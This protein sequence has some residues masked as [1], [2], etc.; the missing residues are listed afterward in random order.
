MTERRKFPSSPFFHGVFPLLKTLR[1]FSTGGMR[2]SNICGR[3]ISIFSASVVAS[4]TTFSVGFRQVPCVQHQLNFVGC[5]VL[6][7][8]ARSKRYG[9]F[10]TTKIKMMTRLSL[11][12]IGVSFG[13]FLSNQKVDSFEYFHDVS[14][15]LDPQIPFR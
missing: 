12:G 4:Q 6:S 1:T 5:S 8:E 14:F 7:L 2:A 13:I 3:S 9:A 15:N 10:Q 11:V